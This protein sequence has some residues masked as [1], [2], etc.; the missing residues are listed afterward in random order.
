VWR[1]LIAVSLVACGDPAPA[2]PDA[3]VVA[4]IDAPAALRSSPFLMQL[5]TSGNPGDA[6]CPINFV[7]LDELGGVAVG[8]QLRFVAQPLAQDFYLNDVR[9][10]GSAKL[11]IQGL[12]LEQWNGTMVTA[13]TLLVEELNPGQSAGPL[14][15]TTPISPMSQVL[16]RADVIY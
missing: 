9:I 6:T 3:H 10:S 8:A 7:A 12:Y 5:C 1:A 16:V 13:A 2:T 15:V 4:E 11:H 14:S